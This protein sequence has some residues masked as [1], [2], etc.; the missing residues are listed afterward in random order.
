MIICKLCGREYNSLT[1]HLIKSHN[2]SPSEYRERF[3]GS[4]IVD[5]EFSKSV[6]K[7]ISKS[8][9]EE[10]KSEQSRVM[11]TLMNEVILK[12]PDHLNRRREISKKNMQKNWESEEFSERVKS[13]ASDTM[14]K[15]WQDED[16]RARHSEL[17]RGLMVDLNK[18]MNNDPEFCARRS[19]RSSELFTRMNL[20][21]WKDDE[22]KEIVKARSSR[23]LKE[24]LERLWQD[25]DYRYK[26][27]IHNSINLKNQGKGVLSTPHRIVSDYLNSIGVNH[28][29]EE[30]VSGVRVDIYIPDSSLVIEVNGE[31]WHGYHELSE[32]EMTENQREGY[33]RD[34]RRMRLFNDKL[35]F[36]WERRDIYEGDY[37]SK[38]KAYLEKYH[39]SYFEETN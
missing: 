29:N 25:E 4:E 10:R 6:G 38:I 8:W 9:T 18:R 22:Y 13:A 23:V 16:Y 24:T 26:M 12:D 33:L 19:S 11:S 21:N 1:L 30:I 15:L 17:S 32:E 35:L 37:K 14:I 34:L 20:E 27:S 31:Y 7:S 28:L 36:L 2:I 3:P 39:V 5:K